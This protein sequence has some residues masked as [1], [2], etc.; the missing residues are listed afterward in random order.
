MS[1]TDRRSTRLT[2]SVSQFQPLA[3]VDCARNWTQSSSLLVLIQPD[4]AFAWRCLH[5]A[6]VKRK[7]SEE[8]LSRSRWSKPTVGWGT[9]TNL[10]VCSVIRCFPCLCPVVDRR[11][12][13]SA[14]YRVEPVRTVPLLLASKSNDTTQWD[15]TSDRSATSAATNQTTEAKLTNCFSTAVKHRQL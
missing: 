14:L 11:R 1:V 10:Q 8:R 9:Q 15:G 13:Y 3:F 12:N 6:L 7:V 5:V 4:P 2:S